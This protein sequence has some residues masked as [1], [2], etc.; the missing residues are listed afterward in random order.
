MELVSRHRSCVVIITAVAVIVGGSARASVLHPP[1]R[2]IAA[3]ISPDGEYVYYIQSVYRVHS[4][5]SL[6]D[7][8][9]GVKAFPGGGTTVTFLKV[10]EDKLAVRRIKI[11]TGNDELVKGLPVPPWIGATFRPG[12]RSEDGAAEWGS[13]RWS[14]GGELQ[15]AIS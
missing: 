7:F 12:W 9:K 4:H 1:R 2:T 15:F 5:T 11:K 14:D 8:W 13:L 6:S 10:W 3:T